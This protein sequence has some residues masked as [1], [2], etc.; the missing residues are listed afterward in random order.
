MIATV[1]E[2]QRGGM[3]G[4]P[5]ACNADNNREE[6]GAWVGGGTMERQIDPSIIN[7]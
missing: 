4:Y 7:E 1:V 6:C 3:C 2:V 5:G